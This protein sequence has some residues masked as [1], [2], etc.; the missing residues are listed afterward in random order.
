MNQRDN[1]FGFSPASISLKG[2]VTGPM[3]ALSIPVIIEKGALAFGK[4]IVNSMSTIYSAL[5]VGALGISNNIGGFTTNPQNGFQEGGSAIISQN[6]GAGEPKRALRAFQCVLVINVVIGFIFMSLSLLFLD[7][8]SWLFAGDDK[9]FL[10]MISSI[11]RFEA[12]GAVPLGINAAVLALL[13]GFG[14]TRLTLFINFSRVFL[15]RIPVLWFLQNFTDLGN[16][17][18]GIVMGVSNFLTGMTALVIGIYEIRKICREYD[19][20]FF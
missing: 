10:Q 13:Y 16:V 5:T 19:I 6:L 1:A 20:R 15:Y 8:I 14:K 4:V 2:N 7:Q 11:Y 18:V 9:Q 17:S 12:L 3:I